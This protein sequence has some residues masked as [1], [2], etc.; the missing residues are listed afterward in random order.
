[1]HNK[2]GHYGRFDLKYL[3]SLQTACWSPDGSV[4]L[5]A[6]EIE[7]IIYSLSFS[8]AQDERKAVIG[9]SHSAIAAVDLS[10]V[11][12]QGEDGNDIK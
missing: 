2:G 6:T 5:F 11:L 3:I 1:M 10:E 8:I 7:P 12:M 9:G 4:L